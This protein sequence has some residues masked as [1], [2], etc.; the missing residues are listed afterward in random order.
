MMI[1]KNPIQCGHCRNTI[2]FRLGSEPM[3]SVYCLACEDA[4]THEEEIREE[5][6][7]FYRAALQHS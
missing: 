1:F 4:V 3:G 6:A 2:A 7:K 5:N